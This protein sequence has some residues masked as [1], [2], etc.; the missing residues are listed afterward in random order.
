MEGLNVSKI[1]HCVESATTWMNGG[2]TYDK[3]WLGQ[4]VFIK[5]QVAQR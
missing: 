1:F 4:M 5:A 3:V 2:A